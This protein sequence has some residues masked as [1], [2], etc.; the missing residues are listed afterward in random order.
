MASGGSR[1]D[2]YIDQVYDGEDHI[3][4]LEI[5]KTFESKKP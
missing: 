1:M 5:K 3:I 4:H 2:Y